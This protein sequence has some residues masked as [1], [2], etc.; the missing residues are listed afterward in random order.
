MQ[1]FRRKARGNRI[2]LHIFGCFYKIESNNYN[3]ETKMRDST[4]VQQQSARLFQ[5]LFVEDIRNLEIII[6]LHVTVKIEFQFQ[7]NS[8]SAP[9]MN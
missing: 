3:S 5:M 4:T 1:L 6:Y 7:I 2:E 9:R 8:T